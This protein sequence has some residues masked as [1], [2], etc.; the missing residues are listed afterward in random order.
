LVRRLSK[1]VANLLQVATQ[2]VDARESAPLLAVSS[3]RR[4]RR[5]R[6]LLLL[7][8][9]YTIIFHP[10]Y[11][12]N[13]CIAFSTTTTTKSHNDVQN[14]VRLSFW[15]DK[16]FGGSTRQANSGNVMLQLLDRMLIMEK[17]HYI[18]V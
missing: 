11:K 16:K 18:V 10:Q 15:A 9:T 4:R 8:R 6:R 2:D 5:R 12:T 7:L 13:Y 1:N 17:K 3:R 14:R